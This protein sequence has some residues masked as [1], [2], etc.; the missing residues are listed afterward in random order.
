MTTNMKKNTEN[1]RPYYKFRM[2]LLQLMGLIG[3]SAL[4]VTAI[5][6][7]VVGV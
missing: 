1:L 3:I 5:L 6:K 2:S 7:W 4:V